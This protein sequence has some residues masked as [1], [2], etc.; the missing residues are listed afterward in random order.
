[1]RTETRSS[2][3]FC[4]ASLIGISLLF[5]GILATGCG[6]KG[7][8]RKTEGKTTDKSGFSQEKDPDSSKTWSADRRIPGDETE[9]DSPETEALRRKQR[10]VTKNLEDASKMIKSANLEG[11]LRLVQR[12]QQENSTDPNVTMQT[13]YMQAMIYHRQKDGTKRKEAMNQMLKSMET[14]QKDPRFK[15]AHEDGQ[16]SMEVIKQSLDS[17]GSRYG[18]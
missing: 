2:H 17:A 12:V 8:L 9:P 13:W 10:D 7:G 5:W 3:A 14:L 18:K 15:Q 4:N 11:A 16:D 6:Y 1:M